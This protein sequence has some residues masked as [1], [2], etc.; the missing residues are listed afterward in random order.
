MVLFPFHF[1]VSAFF[2]TVDSPLEMIF[3]TFC[4]VIG[5]RQWIGI[6]HRI[7]S[8]LEAHSSITLEN[9]LICIQLITPWN[10]GDIWIPLVAAYSA[11]LKFSNALKDNKKKKYYLNLSIP[12]QIYIHPVSEELK[13]N[14][15][16]PWIW[17][18]HAL[19]LRILSSNLNHR[20]SS[21]IGVEQKPCKWMIWD[22]IIMI[23]MFYLRRNWRY[24]HPN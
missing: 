5:R 18:F 8:K 21:S 17:H 19:Y 22:D 12:L 23:F 4:L 6:K 11:F 16:L 24:N 2:M 13:T 1:V 14:Y 7:P 3:S 15:V 10:V 20:L 9:I